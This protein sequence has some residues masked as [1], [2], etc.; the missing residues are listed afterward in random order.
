ML[1][2]QQRLRNVGPKPVDWSIWDV[3]QIPAPAWVFFPANPNSPHKNGILPLGA[4]QDQWT[5]EGGLIITEYRGTSGKIGADS[6]AGWM[7]GVVGDLAYIKPFR[8]R[9]ADGTYPDNGS[10]AEVGPTKSRCPTSRWRSSVPSPTWS[11]AKKPPTPR[12]GPWQS[13]ASRSGSARTCPAPSPSCGAAGCCRDDPRSC[14]AFRNRAYLLLPA[15]ER[16]PEC[17]LQ[18]AAGASGL[19]AALR[20]APELSFHYHQPRSTLLP[21]EAWATGA[22]LLNSGGGSFP[23]SLLTNDLGQPIGPP[24]GDWSPPPPPPRQPM[25]G[26]WCRLEP[27]DPD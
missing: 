4:G 27:L 19:K 3:T 15:A 5:N 23:M 8:P 1:T 14:A 20:H 10:T 17:G 21:C 25:A 2:V 13:S 18:A 24:L 7:V 22:W 16:L 11:R 26:R 9:R 6:A 12:P